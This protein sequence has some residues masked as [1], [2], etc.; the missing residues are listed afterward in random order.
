VTPD[1]ALESVGGLRVWESTPD[2]MVLVDEAGTIRA[3]NSEAHRVFGHAP[4]ELVG[5]SVDAVVPTDLKTVHAKHRS[6]FRSTPARRA[7][8]AGLRLAALRLDGT[9]IAV[10]IALAPLEDGWTIAAVRDMSAAT[11]IEE[12]LVEATRR[13]LVAEDRERIARDLHDT[14]IQELFALGMTLQ[15]IV[16]TTVDPDVATQVDGVV[17]GL[18]EVMQ[19]IRTAI[20]DVGRA[21]GHRDGLRADIVDV[22]AGFTPS[23]G[24]EATVDFRGPVDT[25]VP[26]SHRE[27]IVAVVREG[28]ANVAR[29]A[30]ASAAGV[31]LI[32]ADGL[33]TVRI[34]DDGRGIPPD[35]TR[36]SG[37]ANLATRASNLGGRL[38]VDRDPRGGTMLRWSAPVDTL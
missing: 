32:V 16:A 13:R 4:G 3:A 25:D 5:K 1:Q 36:R 27:H 23:L 10:H 2:G 7:M 6:D 34:S 30:D 12:R 11:L 35:A 19:A 31:S 21:G 15:S 33:V 18:D 8:G 24:F 22:A 38:E 29:H 9:E 28:L 37:L 26:E 20:F 17:V 14:V